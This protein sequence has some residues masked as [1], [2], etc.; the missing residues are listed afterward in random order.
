[1]V[2][3]DFGGGMD[4]VTPRD[5]AVECWDPGNPAIDVPRGSVARAVRLHAER[6]LDSL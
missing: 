3:A 5:E 2:G 6:G 1:M 4:L